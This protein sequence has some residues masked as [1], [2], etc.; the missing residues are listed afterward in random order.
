M[1]KVPKKFNSMSLS[2]QEDWLVKK[3]QAAVDEL[4]QIK[5]LLAMVRGGMKVQP[6]VEDVPGM[7]YE[8]IPDNV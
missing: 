3:H 6:Q 5:K 7:D 4:E 1:F 2:D 8:I